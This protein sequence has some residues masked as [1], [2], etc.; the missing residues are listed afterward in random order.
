MDLASLEYRL[1]EDKDFRERFLD[2]PVE[3]LEGEGMKL[4]E[5][6]RRALPELTES[7][8][9]RKSPPAG[10]TLGPDA[11]REDAILISISKDF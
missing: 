9:H 11:S 10:S 5:T 8:R 7:L 4:P 2:A 1:N 6:A 3:T